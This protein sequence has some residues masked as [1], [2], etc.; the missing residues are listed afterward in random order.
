MRNFLLAHTLKIWVALAFILLIISSASPAQVWQKYNYAPVGR[1]VSPVAVLT[2]SGTVTNPSNVLSG[3]PTTITGSYSHIVLD[4]GREVGGYISLTFAGSSDTAQ[5]VGI[6]FSESALNAGPNS[7]SSNGCYDCGDGALTAR[8]PGASTYTVLPPHLR[9]GFRYLTVFLR[10][11]GWV[12]LSE[13]SLNYSPD[14]D[15]AVPNQYPNYF[16]SSDDTL[17]SIWYAGAYTVQTDILRNDE[18]RAWG[19]EGPP[20]VLWD[21]GATI[22]EYGDVVLTD[23]AKRDRTVWPGDMG[24]SLATEYVSLFDLI[25]ARDSLQTLYNHQNSSNGALPYAGPPMNFT[26]SDTY[27]LWTL[28]GTCAYYLYSGDKTWLDSIWSQFKLGIAFSLSELDSNGLLNVVN[29]YDW[30]RG[31]QGGDNIEANAILYGLLTRAVYLAEVEG[32][33]TDASS[34][35]ASAAALKTRIN[36]LLWDKNIGAYRDNPSNPFYPQDGNALAVWYGVVDSPAKARSISYALNENWNNIGSRSPEYS[37]DTSWP[38]ISP[39]ASSFEVMSNF[40]AGYDKRALDLMRMTW[41][42]MLT[43]PQG[44]NSTFWE[45]L[46]PDGSFDSFTSLAHGWSTGP[47]SALT[48]YVLGLQPDTVSGQTYHVIPHPGDLTYAE[49]SLTLSPGNAISVSFDAGASCQSF[50]LQ[51]NAAANTGSLGTIGVPRFGANHTVLVN[52]ATAWNGTNFV[53][54]PGIAGARQ[55]ADYIYFLGV[56]PGVRTFSFS[57]GT[58]C[59]APPEQ[60]TFCSDEGGMCQFNGTQRVRFGKQGKYFYGI[61]SGGVSCDRPDFGGDPAPGYYKSCEY[62]S[63][64]YTVCALEGQTCSFTGIKEIRYGL[65]GQWAAKIVTGPVACND[66]TFGN[67]LPDVVKRCEYRSLD[68][69]LDKTNKAGL[70]QSN[71]C[72]GANP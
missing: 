21:N 12:E 40:V 67:P 49:G 10:S 16:Y 70:Y 28:M 41:G 45:R 52:G 7:D 48:F 22:G 15:R 6:A 46:N 30:G 13:V 66:A 32:D 31:D 69:V 3:K 65:N 39:F 34:W 8:V 59:P 9:G 54:S 60:W 56:Q 23:G 27:H 51:V 26:G 44:T 68:P 53:G 47:T 2:T 72:K 57:D 18:G 63:E 24:I 17:N 58:A 29:T 43:A 71:H 55:D 36:L 35:A 38:D 19:P 25:A 42:Y 11:T 5:S 14:P 1:T 61:F 33:S 50:S 20:Q 62:S 37:F 64:L 4:F